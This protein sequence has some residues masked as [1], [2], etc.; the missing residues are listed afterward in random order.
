MKANLPPRRLIPRWRRTKS[1]LGMPEATFSSSESKRQLAL[2][3]SRLDHA[4]ETWKT[5]P[6]TGLLGDILSYSIDNTLREKIIN[7]VRVDPSVRDA[8]T[9]TQASFIDQLLGQNG[10]TISTSDLSNRE[11]ELSICSPVVRNEVSTLRR[12]LSANPANPLALLDLAQ[13]QLASGNTQR[14]ERSV[15]SALSLSPNNRIA[16][17]TLARL[18]VHQREFDKAHGLISR[19]VRTA[20]DPWLMATEIALA[21]V[22]DVPSRFAGKG[23][24]FVRD[25]SA[26]I[27]HLSELAG[28]LGGAELSSGRM[29]RAREMFRLALMAPNDNVVAQAV[30]HQQLLGIDLS[31]P[32]QRRAVMS[33][34]EAQ[35]LLAW[36]SLDC[37]NA[38]HHSLIWHDEEPFSSRPLQF[39]TT[40]YAAQRNYSSA[41][42]LAKRGLISDPKDPSLLANLAYVTACTGNLADAERVLLKL[43]ALKQE[44]YNGIAL[45]T[46]GLMEM[47]QGY[48][49]TGNELYEAAMRMF[50]HRRE[51]GLEA[52]CCVYFAKSAADTGHPDRDAIFLRAE[53]LYKQ[54]PS[55][56]AA[57]VLRL[58]NAN[59]QPHIQHV[60]PRRLSQWIF[61]SKTESLIPIHGVTAPGAPPL[62]VKK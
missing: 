12:I 55:P 56:D 52:L 40:I 41:S 50:R 3:P 21:E 24:K 14:A 44:K 30:T 29:K 57:V 54:H 46:A 17:R 42:M 1:V 4:I 19:H 31:A 35:T 53:S 37:V 36:E 62:I 5:S 16:L 23:F 48:W 26:N 2:D 13:F 47:Q 11:E 60:S 61:D 28:A 9:A 38:E 49:D 10:E 6:T 51:L 33:A 45:A 8:A 43:I 15:L 27:A 22:A 32:I 34:H 39:L 59:I 25:K 58:L 7:L 20:S 18:Y